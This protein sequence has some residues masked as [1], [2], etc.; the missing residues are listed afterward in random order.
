MS[1][2]ALE[3]K[4]NGSLQLA[5]LPMD[6]DRPAI[7]DRDE[8]LVMCTPAAVVTYA[9]YVVVAQVLY[10]WAASHRLPFRTP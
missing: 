10:Y 7:L 3:A 1:T 4:V 2:M 5:A 8:S 9:V 6:L